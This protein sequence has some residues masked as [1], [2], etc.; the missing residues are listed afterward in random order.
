MTVQLPFGRR[1]SSG[2]GGNPI[3]W[4][5]AEALQRLRKRIDPRRVNGGVFL[6]LGGTVVKSHG[7]T[8]ALGFSTALL[9][10]ARLAERNFPEHLA[11]QLAK[12]DIGDKSSAPTSGAERRAE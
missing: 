11:S 5:D 2:A 1:K 4:R 10:A 12:L 6:G 3:A 9:L 7:D 8:D